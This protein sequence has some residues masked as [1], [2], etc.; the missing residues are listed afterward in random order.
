MAYRAGF[1]AA[2]RMTQTWPGANVIGFLN[3]ALHPVIW[4][5]RAQGTAQS[6]LAACAARSRTAG[7]TMV[8]FASRRDLYS[9]QP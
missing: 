2:A 1:G 8:T 9:T 7:S 6:L 5:D 3:A 4:N